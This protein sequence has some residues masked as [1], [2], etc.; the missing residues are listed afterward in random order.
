MKNYLTI[1]LV[2]AFCT[3]AGLAQTTYTEL[4]KAQ[5]K[6]CFAPLSIVDYRVEAVEGGANFTFNVINVTKF[7]I[8]HYHFTWDAIVEGEVL[9]SG[10]IYSDKEIAP[11]GEHNHYQAATNEAIRPQAERIL[12][13]QE[14]GTLEMKLVCKGLRMSEKK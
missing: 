10:I 8:D 6:H 5:A 2:T 12:Q 13:A 14:D 3:T 9:L 7:Q 1:L 11:D 4:E